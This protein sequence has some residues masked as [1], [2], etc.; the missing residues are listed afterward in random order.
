MAAVM[1]LNFR[2]RSCSLGRAHAGEGKL[3]A[4]EEE[5]EMKMR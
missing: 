4:E 3:S 2:L 5:M 1:V